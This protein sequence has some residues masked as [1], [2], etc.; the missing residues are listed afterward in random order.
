VITYEPRVAATEAASTLSV[1]PSVA[2]APGASAWILQ[3]YARGEAGDSVRDLRR[4]GGVDGA[5]ELL[6]YSYVPMRKPENVNSRSML[7]V[8][9]FMRLRTPSLRAICRPTDQNA[10]A[11]APG[12]ANVGQSPRHETRGRTLCS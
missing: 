4:A 2:N 8:R 9:P 5:H 12:A 3:R 1:S 6:K 11:F 7:A 10:F